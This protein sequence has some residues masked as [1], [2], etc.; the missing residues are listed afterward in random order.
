MMVN[1]YFRIEE[2]T[3]RRKS[4]Q[5]PWRPHDPDQGDPRVTDS[6]RGHR[7]RAHPDYEDGRRASRGLPDHAPFGVQQARRGNRTSA[8]R[9]TPSEAD[10]RSAPRGELAPQRAA[11]VLSLR[12]GLSGDAADDRPSPS[13][14]KAGAAALIKISRRVRAARR[15][16][17]SQTLPMSSL[18]ARGPRGGR[19]RSR[20][21][22]APRPRAR[23][24]QEAASA[25]SRARRS[26]TGTKRPSENLEAARRRTSVSRRCRG[27]RPRRLGQ[28]GA[29]RPRASAQRPGVCAVR[30]VD[31][32]APR[33]RAGHGSRRG[34]R[35]EEAAVRGDHED[36]LTA[37]RAGRRDVGG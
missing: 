34:F 24:E 35:D 25:M 8:D 28:L 12:R 23:R 33:M 32:H 4:S 6:R 21:S 5:P 22:R 27:A 29:Q 10:D 2:K 13:L 7:R 19:H 3:V 17:N 37:R 11:L 30:G 9:E 14:A 20:D 16:P 15:R 26:R 36:F 18:A 1:R 31:R